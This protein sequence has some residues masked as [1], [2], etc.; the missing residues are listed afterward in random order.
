MD[1][2]NSVKQIDV[3]AIIKAMIKTGKLIYRH[4]CLIH[5]IYPN[6]HMRA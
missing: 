4:T 2:N 6:Y 3:T 5:F 1:N